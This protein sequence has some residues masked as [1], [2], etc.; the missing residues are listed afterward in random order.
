[1]AIRSGPVGYGFTACRIVEILLV[2]VLLCL[3]SFLAAEINA[4]YGPNQPGPV[5]G[6][7]IVSVLALT[8]SF[9]TLLLHVCGPLPYP[10][11]VGGDFLC[12]LGILISAVYIGQPLLHL[13]CAVVGAQNNH[14]DS[15]GDVVNSLD[16]SNYATDYRFIPNARKL[17]PAIQNVTGM[18]SVNGLEALGETADSVISKLGSYE[19]WVGRVENV[20]VQMKGAWGIGIAACF[21]YAGTAVLAY[22]LWRRVHT[23]RMF[24]V[25]ETSDGPV[26]KEEFVPAEMMREVSLEVDG[27]EEEQSRGLVRKGSVKSLNARENQPLHVAREV[28]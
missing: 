4:L 20:C 14:I 26:Y 24:Y 8:Y 7:L 12:F 23:I 10:F 21:I 2:A 25:E 6:A 15:L 9:A 3:C 5:M 19:Q 1:M 22:I 27:M 28:V 18:E 17:F 16:S 13:D 11:A